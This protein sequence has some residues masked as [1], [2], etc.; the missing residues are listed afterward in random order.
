MVDVS[1]RQPSSDGSGIVRPAGPDEVDPV[2]LFRLSRYD[3]LLAIIPFVLLLAAI[4]GHLTGAPV[5]AAMGAGALA[6]L[7]LLADGLAVNPPR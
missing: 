7:P 4:F 3:A 2:D 1:K 5:W 6:A